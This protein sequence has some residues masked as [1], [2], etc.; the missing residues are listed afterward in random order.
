MKLFFLLGLSPSRPLTGL[1]RYTVEFDLLLSFGAVRLILVFWTVE[2]WDGMASVPR[3][4]WEDS[5]P[6]GRR[7]SLEMEESFWCLVG[8]SVVTRLLSVRSEIILS[9]SS[10]RGTVSRK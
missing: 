7:T 4:C 8:M 6:R 9:S 1:S 5:V 2:L 3:T 10:N